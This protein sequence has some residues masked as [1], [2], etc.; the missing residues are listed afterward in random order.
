M[1]DDAEVVI[2]S[3][4]CTQH[5]AVC[6]AAE[7][8]GYPTLKVFHNGNAVETYSGARALDDLKGFVLGKRK[9]LLEETTA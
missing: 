1:S 3:V 9:F 4:D 6:G 8:K 7:I 5:Q 2:A